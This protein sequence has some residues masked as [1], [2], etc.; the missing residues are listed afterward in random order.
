MQFNSVY[1][2]MTD[3]LLLHSITQFFF[4]YAHDLTILFLNISGFFLFNSPEGSE[5]GNTSL[6]GEYSIPK[7]NPYADDSELRPEI[8]ALGLRNPWRCSFDS[9][10]P[11]YFYCGDVG[12]V[13]HPIQDQHALASRCCLTCQLL[14]LSRCVSSKATACSGLGIR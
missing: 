3:W 7:D 4:W 1:K 12:Q 8:W 5:I 11:S 6:W 14:I 2:S 10:R 9:E 13:Y